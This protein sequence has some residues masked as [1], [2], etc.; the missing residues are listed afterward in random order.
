MDQA[1]KVADTYGRLF[2]DPPLLPAE[3]L[4]DAA[5]F[6]L[7]Q[8]LVVFEPMRRLALDIAAGDD[9]S[10]VFI[11]SPTDEHHYLDDYPLSTFDV[12]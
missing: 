11:E 6:L 7:F 2:A 8:Q 1:R 3:A 5:F 12:L 10:P 4:S 9:G